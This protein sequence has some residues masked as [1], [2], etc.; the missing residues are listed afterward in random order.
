MF[1]AVQTVT[2]CPDGLT[3]I[4]LVEGRT[5]EFG[6][7]FADFMLKRG[8]IEAACLKRETKPL[9]IANEVKD[10]EKPKRRGRPPKVRVEE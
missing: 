5:Y 9:P 10:G 4:S 1:K 7:S 2:C 3:A 8:F 6:P